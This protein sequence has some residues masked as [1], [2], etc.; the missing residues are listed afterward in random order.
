MDWEYVKEAKES[1]LE[2]KDQGFQILSLEQNT[3][4]KNLKDFKAKDCFA[5]I[6]GNEVTGVSKESISLS[7]AILE[8]PMQGKKESLNVSVATGLGLFVLI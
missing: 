1:I 3:D 5:L 2:L 6:V 4:S 8:I 7:D